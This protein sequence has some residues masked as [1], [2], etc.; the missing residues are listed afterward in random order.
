[1]V[2]KYADKDKYVNAIVKKVRCSTAKKKEIK[3]QLLSDIAIAMEDGENIEDIIKNMGSVEEMAEEFNSNLSETELKKHKTQ[4]RMKIVSVISVIIIIIIS[5]IRWVLPDQM[6]FGASG[7]FEE[8]AVE[9]QMKHIILLLNEND[10]EAL[11]EISIEEM[12]YVLDEDTLDSL[13]KMISDDWGEFEEFGNIYLAEAKQ[14]G[15]NFAIGQV[16]VL[17]ENVPVTYQ[18]TLDEDMKL[19]G[20]YM[21]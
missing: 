1:M 19:A 8:Q 5:G 16:T 17:Y 6:V 15:Q 18:I 4:K 21:R 3:K 10:H 14:K 11:I 12:K 20:F 7:L 2:E 13:K 9:E